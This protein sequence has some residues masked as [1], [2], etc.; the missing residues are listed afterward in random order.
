MTT[1]Q[2]NAIAN[3]EAQ[4]E[5]QRFQA[6]QA[7]REVAELDAYSVLLAIEVKLSE[8]R[9]DEARAMAAEYRKSK[10]GN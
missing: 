7:G 2:H 6:E 1:Q 5:A 3:V 10:K 9:I 8:G 4:H